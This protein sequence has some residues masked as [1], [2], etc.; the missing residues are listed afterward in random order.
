MMAEECL[1]EAVIAQQIEDACH[2]IFDYGYLA[3]RPDRPVGPKPTRKEAFEALQWL[4]DPRWQDDRRTVFSYAGYDSQNIEDIFS[5][6]DRHT[7]EIAE[8]RRWARRVL[9]S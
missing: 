3:D 4:H 9:R 1:W 2:V 5:D 6:P 7:N 8:H